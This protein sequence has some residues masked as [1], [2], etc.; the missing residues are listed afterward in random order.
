MVNC[1]EPDADEVILMT[2]KA[3]GTGRNL[4]PASVVFV[5]HVVQA[6]VFSRHHTHAGACL[7]LCGL[8]ECNERLPIGKEMVVRSQLEI[9]RPHSLRL[10]S[11]AASWCVELWSFQVFIDLSAV[12]SFDAPLNLRM[13][14]I[15]ELFCCSR[16]LPVLSLSPFSTALLTY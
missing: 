15:A 10:R 16:A 9:R 3:H 2:P 7:N 13:A 11:H 1:F 6:F 5:Q 4:K 14:T 12:R 8:F